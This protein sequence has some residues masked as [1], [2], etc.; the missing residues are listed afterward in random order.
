MNR[1]VFTALVVAHEINLNVHPNYE[2]YY[3]RM[4][5]YHLNRGRNHPHVVG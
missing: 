3:Q 5:Y 1:A 2:E 4:G